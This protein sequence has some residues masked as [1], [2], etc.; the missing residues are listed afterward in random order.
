MQKYVISLKLS[1][2]KY[3]KKKSILKN[4]IV[5]SNPQMLIWECKCNVAF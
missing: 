2:Q 4:V 3:V 1:T 5:F